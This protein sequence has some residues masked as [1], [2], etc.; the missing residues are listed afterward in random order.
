MIGTSVLKELSKQKSEE[1]RKN[2]ISVSKYELRGYMFVAGFRPVRSKFF[3]DKH[4][5]LLQETF[6]IVECLLFFSIRELSD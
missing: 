6:L 1:Y 5:S 3:S 4:S 2:D